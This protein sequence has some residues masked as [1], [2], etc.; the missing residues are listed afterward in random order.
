MFGSRTCLLLLDCAVGGIECAPAARTSRET[1]LR[2]DET[3]CA[4]GLILPG[5]VEHAW[6]RAT[7]APGWVPLPSNGEGFQLSEASNAYA[8][9]TSWLLEALTL[10]GRA[11]KVL[12]SSAPLLLVLAASGRE[13][14]LLREMNL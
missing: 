5:S 14:G 3:P 11:L 2:L 10:A 9:G 6:L 4:S 13:G 12:N 8:F 7:A 1:C